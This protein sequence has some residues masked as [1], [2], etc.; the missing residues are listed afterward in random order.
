M[1]FDIFCRL[2]NQG[3]EV[4]AYIREEG[5]MAIFEGI[6][7]FREAFAP[8]I[9]EMLRQM[10]KNHVRVSLFLP[11][12]GQYHLNYLIASGWIDSGKDAVSASKL[13]TAGKN[14]SDVFDKKRVFFGFREDEVA[15]QISACRKQGKTTA[16]LGME[17]RVTPLIP[18]ADISIGCELYDESTTDSSIRTAGASDEY[19][20]AVNRHADVLIRR[21]GPNGGGLAG[22]ACAVGTAR[23]I[24]FRMMLAMQYLLVAQL[25]RV[26]TV[27]LPMLFGYA[28]ISP[29][30]LLI[31]GVWVDLAYVL[32]CAFHHCSPDVLHEAPDYHR[33]FKAPF[34]ARPDW[35]CATLVCGFFTVLSAWVL[36]GTATTPAGDGLEIY[37]FLSLLL[38]QTCLLVCLLRSTGVPSARWRS[39]VSSL[40][41]I[42]ALICLILPILLIPP[43]G[44]WFGGRGLSLLTLLLA[45]LSPLFLIGCY[46]LSMTYRKKI[47]RMFRVYF[48][49]IKR[50]LGKN[51]N[52]RAYTED[53]SSEEKK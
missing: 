45:L 18:P 21:A 37:M 30:L 46:F 4:C 27:V 25:L 31:S 28:M 26:T 51:R 6:L 52:R 50:R 42:G 35:L 23:S 22:I 17:Y 15:E 43:V 32:I 16:C 39:Y 2:K 12:E 41:V 34:R 7:S 40:L 20:A 48:H 33:F 14:L 49:G 29:A 53:K 44:A 36:M 24:H 9:V 19:N 1:L 8:N 3:T 47:R 13:R 11:E 10:E 5:G 38:A